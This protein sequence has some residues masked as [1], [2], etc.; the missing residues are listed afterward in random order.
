[1]FKYLALVLAVVAVGC[2]GED[3]HGLKSSGQ[4]SLLN[5]NAPILDQT[6]FVFSGTGSMDA[7]VSYGVTAPSNSANTVSL[8][9]DTE[10]ST[11]IEGT[12]FVIVTPTDELAAG[13]T[14]GEFQ[15]KFLEDGAT[16]EGKKVVFKLQSATLENAIFSQTYTFNVSLTCPVEG[17]LGEFAA[18][19]WWLG[20]SEHEI[21]ATEDVPNQFRVKDFWEDNSD[22]P[23]FIL[24]YNPDTFAIT[25][26]EQ[27]TG[28]EYSAG[29]FIYAKQSTTIASSFNPCTRVMH[30]GVYYYIPGV[31]NYGDK[32]ELFTGI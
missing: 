13:E 10:N 19:T 25:F 5:F 31:G 32:D 7:T 30:V 18:T 23:D 8:V 24:N 14:T 20:D 12:D 9:V 3:D 11:A 15:I 21:I 28:Y 22:A 6:V 26:P 29:K 17:F 2:T 16:Q 27:S 1:M 4:S